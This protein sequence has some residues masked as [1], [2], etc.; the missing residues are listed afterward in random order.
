MLR[1]PASALFRAGVIA[2]GLLALAPGC[3]D[4]LTE[5]TAPRGSFDLTDILIRD[6]TIQASGSS[7]FRQYLPMNGRVNLLGGA[8]SAR[9]LMLIQFYPSFFPNRD[10]ITV[11]SAR[12]R[13]RAV[14]W[15]GTGNLTFTVH[16]VTSAWSQTAARWDSLP[17]YEEAVVRGTGSVGT[18]PDTQ[19][20]WI[21]LDTALVREWLRP[22]TFTQYGVILVPGAGS[23]LI[24]GFHSFDYDSTG[25]YPALEVI[26]RGSSGGVTDTAL[27]FRGIDTFVGNVDPPPSAPGLFF[28]QAGVAWRAAL[29]FDLSFIPEGATVHSS[30]LELFW[31]RAASAVN[32]FSAD[33]AVIG[34]VIRSATDPKNFSSQGTTGEPADS[35]FVFD[36]RNAAQSW[37]NRPNYGL[38]L[39]HGSYT[40]F[41]SFDRYAFFGH[42]APTARLRPSLRLR[43]STER[44]AGS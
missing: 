30:R 12:L 36:L 35:A 10:T 43:Y 18:A 29:Q 23:T 6:T 42:D 15:T 8:E 37:V 3:S 21:P 7:M 13:L 33:T 41:S 4:P 5:E 26:A 20:V 9:A 39:R 44:R 28:V 40:E 19:Q 38:L 11:L 2:C 14:T 31:D 17:S 16:K 22:A 25:F 1:H 24:R 34:Y 27:Y 32:R